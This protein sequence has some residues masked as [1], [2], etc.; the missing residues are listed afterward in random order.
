MGPAKLLQHIHHICPFKEGVLP[1]LLITSDRTLLEQAAHEGT[2]SSRYPVPGE[3]GR[4]VSDARG[5]SL[6]PQAA[7][8]S[9]LD[10]SKPVSAHTTAS[11][12]PV[13][14]C[15]AIASLGALAFGYHLGV[16][17][18][19]LA[20][21]AADLGFAKNAALQGTVRPPCMKLQ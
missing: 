12:G 5:Y 20:A 7:A 10:V 15:V 18:G 2:C 19:P 1:E 16:V 8:D 17:N 3:V 14:T 9:E 13:I 6:I 21:I 4:L 11:L